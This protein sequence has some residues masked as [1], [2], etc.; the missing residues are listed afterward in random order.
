MYRNNITSARKL[1]GK[2]VTYIGDKKV[3]IEKK[4]TKTFFITCS[5]TF[6]GLIPYLL[7]GASELVLPFFLGSVV[8]SVFSSLI[9]ILFKENREIMTIDKNDNLFT[10][11]RRSGNSIRIINQYSFSDIKSL[12]IYNDG[13]NKIHVSLFVSDGN[14]FLLSDKLGKSENYRQKFE[15]AYRIASLMGVPVSSI[16]YTT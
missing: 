4:T 13:N 16:K 10:I 2:W 1:G 8:C 11:E 15:F 12:N 5:L 14:I 7:S 3:T 6:L 9:C